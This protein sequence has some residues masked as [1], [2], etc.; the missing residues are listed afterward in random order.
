MNL[1]NNNIYDCKCYINLF[2]IVPAIMESSNALA[3]L[4]T[5][6]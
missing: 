2:N 5:I 3:M 6:Y 4:R 1:G